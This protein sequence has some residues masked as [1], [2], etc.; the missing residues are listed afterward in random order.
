MHLSRRD[1]FRSALAA[2]LAPL[3]PGQDASPAAA[4]RPL[5]DLHKGASSPV[6]V[7]SVELLRSG[8]VFIVRSTSSDGAIGLAV[9]NDRVRYL[10]PI[11]KDLVI[12]YFIG[13]DARDLESLV[14]GVY[15]HQSNYKLAGIALWCCV[16]WVEFS[17]FDL[18]GKVA[19]KPVHELLGGALR[20]EVPVYLSSLRRD[21]TPEEE[22]DWVGRRLAETGA[23]AVKLKIGGRMSRNADAAPGRTDKLV[24]LARKTFGDGVTVYVD[25]NGSY[26]SPKAIEVGR[27]LESHRVG[28][29]EEPCPFEE[30]EETKRVAD[31]LA[32]PVAGGEQD[33][34]LPRFAWMVRNRAVDIVQPDLSY[35]GGF[36][37]AARVARVAAA[38]GLVIT[39]HSPQAGPQPAY[40]LHFAAATANIGPHLEFNGAPRRPETWFSPTFDVKDGKL[41]VPGGPGLGVAID[42]EVLRK[43]VR[44]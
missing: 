29:F 27:M 24:P 3:L 41:P 13:K 21:T 4:D 19:G 7:A 9:P 6:K 37:R 34:S 28:F 38:A 35:N 15:V 32:M 12:P 31:A 10:Y 40:M 22:V 5:F 43:A 23:K 16:S 8:D 25:A 36:I 18:L 20:R 14:D 42:A 33:A 1:L 44:V 17:L 30:L 11:L 26:D 2:G 39:P